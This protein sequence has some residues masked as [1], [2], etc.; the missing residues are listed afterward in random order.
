[1]KA[2]IKKETLQF[3]KALKKSNERGWFEKNKD[4]FVAANENFIQFVQALI[5]EVAKFD[6]SVA[7]LDAK[8]S[9]FRGGKARERPS[10]L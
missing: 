7:G 2:T 4:K 1:M 10:G 8:K 5:D 9:V 6:K 3:L